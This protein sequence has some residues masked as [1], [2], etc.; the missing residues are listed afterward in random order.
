M[1]IFYLYFLYI[2]STYVGHLQ[3]SIGL[4]AFT[5]HL[6]HIAVQ[7]NGKIP[8][9]LIVKEG[10]NLY[11]ETAA[12]GKFNATLRNAYLLRVSIL[13]QRFRLRKG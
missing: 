12:R 1:A 5:G 13:K 6:P 11:G 9:H 3:C 4:P 10:W 8:P 7:Q 2:N